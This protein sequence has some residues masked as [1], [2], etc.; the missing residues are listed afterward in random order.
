MR[1]IGT[2][3]KEK[4]LREG[5]KISRLA[6]ELKINPRYLSSLEKN[7]F[8]AIPG[9]TAIIQGIVRSYAQKLGLDADKAA[10]IFRRDFSEPLPRVVPLPA[11]EKTRRLLTP[12][13][14][15]MIIVGV[16]LLWLTF[17]LGRHLLGF[18]KPPVIKVETPREGEEIKG[19]SL[20][21]RG[22]VKGGDVLTL[23]GEIVRLEDDG[24]FQ[25]RIDCQPGENTLILEALSP[26]QKETLYE[27]HF[28][29][30]TNGG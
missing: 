8:R 17:F 4:R 10:A 2:I 7:D 9:G 27:V 16:S 25:K 19:N 29:C 20:L 15:G 18:L 14:V 6:K 26:R 12:S 30:L 3:L 11:E 1:Q 22:K 28:F 5:K 13:L 23:N 24:R 21:V